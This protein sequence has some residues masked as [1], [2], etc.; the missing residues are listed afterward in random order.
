MNFKT[1]S[2]V[3]AFR[4]EHPKGYALGCLPTFRGRESILRRRAVK[5]L[6]L[7]VGNSVLDLACGTGRNFIYLQEAV[8]PEGRIIGF[9]YSAEMLEAAKKQVQNKKWKNVDLVQGD[10]AKLSLDYK[11]DGVL[12][13]LGISAMSNHQT[14]LLRAVKNLKTGRRIA[15][16]DAKPFEGIFSFLNPPIQ[17]TYQKFADWD[18]T[19]DIIGDL[20]KLV[21]DLVIEKHNFKTIYIAT[22]IAR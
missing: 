1:S 2:K 4:G 13:T 19:R 11:V 7:E 15:I 14:A 12:S 5:S 3:Y 20:G 18:S 10:A 9:D 8:G 6:N 17:P 16:M 21:R 22:G